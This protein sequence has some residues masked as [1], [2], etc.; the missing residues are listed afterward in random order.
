MMIR[1]VLF[2]AVLALTL[3][4]CATMNLPGGDDGLVERVRAELAADPML[5]TS[6]VTVTESDGEVVL[7]GFAESLE[8]INV[9]RD[10]VADVEGVVSVRNEVIVQSGG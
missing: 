5:D 10:A 9:I 7:G 3:S 8:D 6:Q 1:P 2:G 4:G